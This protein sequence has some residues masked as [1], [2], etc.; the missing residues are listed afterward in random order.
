MSTFKFQ[1]ESVWI[2]R[3]A[4]EEKSQRH[5]A[6]ALRQR[7]IF[8]D[9]LRQMQQ[10]ITQSKRDLAD[11]LTGTVDLARVSGFARF[12]G[13]VVQRAHAFVTR[14]AVVEKQID[15]ARAT[16]L[17]ATHAR[18]AIELLRDKRRRQW[19]Q[20]QDRREAAELDEIAVQRHARGTVLETVE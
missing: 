4:E 5:L 19:Q 9:Q 11:G 15:T 17:Q 14:L 13:Q 10:T 2:Q 16:L 6:K 3:R 1:F 7:M 20:Q 18:R 8:R 12:N